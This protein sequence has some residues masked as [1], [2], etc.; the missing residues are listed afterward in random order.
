[1]SKKQIALTPARISF[2]DRP[3]EAAPS[4]VS[5]VREVQVD[6]PQCLKTG[7]SIE[8][9]TR[10][11]GELSQKIG[12]LQSHLHI[13]KYS[14]L[15]CSHM[16]VNEAHHLVREASDV[17]SRLGDGHGPDHIDGHPDSVYLEA[18]KYSSLIN[19]MMLALGEK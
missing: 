17:R 19:I 9:K 6:I 5:S 16:L 18:R 15:K 11:R 12:D 3:R 2:F 13:T 14:P 10:I 4:R 8:D 7:L 1:M